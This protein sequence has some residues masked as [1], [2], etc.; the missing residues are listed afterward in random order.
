MNTVEN[1]DGLCGVIADFATSDLQLR[2]KYEFGH[3]GK[4][5]FE[6]YRSNFNITGGS[7][8]EEYEKWLL[9][10]KDDDGIKRGFIESVLRKGK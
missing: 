6:K 5:S 1:F 8:L 10:Q 9:N 4:H 2:C 7:S 3:E